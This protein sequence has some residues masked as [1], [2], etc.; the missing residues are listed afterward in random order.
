MTMDKATWGGLFL[1]GAGIAAGLLLEGGRLSQIL[2]PTAALI[3]FGGTIGAVFIHFPLSAIL[4]AARRLRSIFQESRHDSAETIRMLVS[5]AQQARKEGIVSLDARLG[6]VKD[7]FMKKCLSRVPNAAI[8]IGF[9]FHPEAAS[10]I[11]IFNT[12]SHRNYIGYRFDGT[13]TGYELTNCRAY[14]NRTYGLMDNTG[15]VTY[16]YCHFYANN[17]ATGVSTDVTGTPGP[18]DGGHNLPADTP[19]DVRGFM[20]YPARI[21]LTFDDPGLIDGPHEYLQPLLPLF[22]AKG[23]PLSIATV[24]GYE[25]SNELIPTFQS[26]IDAGFDVNC[27]SVSHQYFTFPNAFTVQYTG[28]AASSVTLSISDKHLTIAAPGDPGAQASWDLT[29]PA[30]GE[31]STGLD[32]LG[33]I[34][35]TLNQRG[36]FSVTADPNM[37]TAVKSEDLADVAAT[38]IKSAALTLTMDKTRLMT[39]EL[40]WSKQWM[41]KNLTGLFGHHSVTLTWEAPTSGPTPD[42][43]NVY[44]SATSGSGYQL[45]ANGVT[46]TTYTD[47][48]VNP[49]QTWYYVTTA[50]ADGLES[51]F[52]NET[53]ATVPGHWVYVYP[54]SFEDPTTEAIAAAAGYGGARGSGVM[55]PSPAADTVLGT[56]IDVQNILSQGAS[57][58][59]QNI[60]DAQFAN[61]LR[62][63]VFK[64]AVWGVPIGIFWHWNEMTRDQ[65]SLMLDVLKSSGATLMTNTQLVDYLLSTQQNAGTTNYV[66]GALG[67]TD[68]RAVPG[69]AEVDAGTTLGDEYKFEVMGIDQSLFGA[70]WEMG[71]SAFVPESLGTVK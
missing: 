41:S 45:I 38:D 55:Q 7:P 65:V 29:A 32:T 13:A 8:P 20:E 10:D 39:D 28:T 58:N 18:H 50:M 3:V 19:P 67:T 33:G 9:Y 42:F 4:G 22:L 43:Y 56:G 57:P 66:D 2:Q 34:I 14:A 68:F 11:H 5:F 24:T 35:A 61:K 21:T 27:H 31:T 47:Y 49:Q 26:W 71:A 37:K 16:D 63:L 12:D 25:L 53:S 15:A 36:V 23:V 1:A 46:A 17:L 6:Q 51:G 30:P 62:A 48:A 59:F 44:R 69:S 40:G 64:S 60:S 54:G 70:R 52:S